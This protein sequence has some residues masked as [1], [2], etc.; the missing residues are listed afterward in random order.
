VD[1]GAEDALEVGDVPFCKVGALL[2]TTEE[3]EEVAGKDVLA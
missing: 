2:V 3:G 1:K